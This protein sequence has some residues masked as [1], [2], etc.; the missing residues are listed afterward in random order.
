M[1][2]LHAD[3]TVVARLTTDQAT[4][5]R[6]Q[7]SLAEHFG[8][9]VAVS[10]AEESEEARDGRW[11]LALHFR[12]RP[13]EAAVRA[14]I[15]SIARPM[16]GEVRAQ[17]LAQELTFQTLAPTDWVRKSLEGLTPVAAGRFVLHG[18]HDRARFP[19][20]RI[21]IE[22]NAGLAFGTGHHGS[23]RGCLLALDR[24][25]KRGPVRRAKARLPRSIRMSKTARAPSPPFMSA[26]GGFARPTVRRRK[27]PAVLDLGTG[28]G[29]L[30]IAAAKALHWPVLAS[31]VDARAVAIARENA[32]S[33]GIASGIEVVHAAG[34]NTRRFQERAPFDLVLANILLEPLMQ[35]ATGLA[36]LVAP[37]GHVVLAGLLNA[38]ARPAL[39]SFR[40]RGFVFG[41][42]ITLGGWTTLVLK[43]RGRSLNWRV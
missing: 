34:V 21:A 40:A 33:N 28:T 13:D 17:E 3:T 23:T 36:R 39:A 25:V 30:A 29:V 4:A 14:L 26:A 20:N 11:S 22:I 27:K 24:I 5:A 35:F 2:S 6:I 1:T 43:R 32:R 8:E 10:I 15:A 41:G 18:T 16:A 31:D 19:A 12:N 9:S 7:D 42:C 38:Q 37:N